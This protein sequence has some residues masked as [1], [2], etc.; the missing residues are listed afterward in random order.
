MSNTV[1][2]IYKPKKVLEIFD[3]TQVVSDYNSP[4]MKNP[5]MMIQ[6]MNPKF[7]LN[8]LYN[9]NQGITTRRNGQNSN[10]MEQDVTPDQSIFARKNRQVWSS[11]DQNKDYQQLERSSLFQ[12]QGKKGNKKKTQSKQSHL[13]TNVLDSHATHERNS[14]KSVRSKFE[15]YATTE[16]TRPNPVSYPQSENYIKA[17]S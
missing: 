9:R 11:L 15:N 5:V 3:R 8:S 17:D 12:V 13:T 16:K 14:S 6:S 2:Q 1:N 4:N 10:Y 7:G